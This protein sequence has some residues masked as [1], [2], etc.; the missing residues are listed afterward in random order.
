M[1]SRSNKS[2]QVQ[3]A[4]S[5]NTNIP[6]DEGPKNALKR[7]PLNEGP[8]KDVTTDASEKTMG[9]NPSAKK[10]RLNT[11]K[12]PKPT[13]KNGKGSGGKNGSNRKTS[14]TTE[15]DTSQQG[16][17]VQKDSK[18]KRPGQKS[19]NVNTSNGVLDNITNEFVGDEPLKDNDSS[20][21]E[22]QEENNFE[23]PED[24]PLDKRIKEL[25]AQLDEL[26]HAQEKRRPLVA[27]VAV[28]AAFKA[29]ARQAKAFLAAPSPPAQKGSN[30]IAAEP[31]AVKKKEQEV[32]EVIARPQGEAG[33]GVRGFNLQNAVGLSDDEEK[34]KDFRRSV[35]NSCLRAGVD[36]DVSFNKQSPE[37]VANVCRKVAHDDPYFSKA[38][39]P[40]Y[41]PIREY[42][43]LVIKNKRK[44]L[45]KA[46]TKA[47]VRNNIDS[48]DEEDNAGA[49]TG[50]DMDQDVDMAVPEE[51]MEDG[52][53]D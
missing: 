33:D 1:S 10:A 22:V 13:N 37:V 39:F 30:Q 17:K 27:H 31:K 46:S 44:Y 28:A 52:N 14:G 49:S 8:D 35:R 5:T 16:T 43:K 51:G 21:E 29:S 6:S 50:G 32:V 34:Y 19:N 45:K 40:G 24:G 25:Q 42:M 47:M 11:N 53:D 3:V 38:R 36:F 48:G 18:S 12:D 20:L 23:T 41:W 7:G 15:K 26:Q 9:G 2:K 4:Q